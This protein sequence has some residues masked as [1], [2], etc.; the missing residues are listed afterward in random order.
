MCIENTSNKPCLKYLIGF[1]AAAKRMQHWIK[2]LMA[3]MFSSC[4]V[5][6]AQAMIVSGS[7]LVGTGMANKLTMWGWIFM[8]WSM[9]VP[10]PMHMHDTSHMTLYCW[11]SLWLMYKL[12]NP[13]LQWVWAIFL[14]LCVCC[15][16]LILLTMACQKQLLLVRKSYCC[17]NS[18]W[19][20]RQPLKH[21]RM[22]TMNYMGM[23]C[24][25]Y[26]S[27]IILAWKSSS[28]IS[29]SPLKLPLHKVCHCGGRPQGSLICVSSRTSSVMYPMILCMIHLC[30]RPQLL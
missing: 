12:D 29:S 11:A 17:C 8:S 28:R 24:H 6:M 25:C 1:Q 15:S 14:Y 10:Y 7:E 19:P 23:G 13:Y 30:R 22:M 5:V 26:C 16:C 21:G 9:H 4:H 20:V 2:Q 27:Y 18:S 3:A